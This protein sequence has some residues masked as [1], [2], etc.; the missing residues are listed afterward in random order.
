MEF[1][2]IPSIAHNTDLVTFYERNLIEAT[3]YHRERHQEE[4]KWLL[5]VVGDIKFACVVE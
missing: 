2:R 1:E 4:N 5:E 3:S